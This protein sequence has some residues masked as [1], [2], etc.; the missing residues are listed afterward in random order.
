MT[1]SVFVFNMK[2]DDLSRVLTRREKR[3]L[4]LNKWFYAKCQGRI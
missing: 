1:D 4:F 2:T 3:D